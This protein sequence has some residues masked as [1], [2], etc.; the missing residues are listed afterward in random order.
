[1]KRAIIFSMMGLALAASAV[2][3]RWSGAGFGHTRSAKYVAL[4]SEVDQR[5]LRPASFRVLLGVTDANPTRWDGSI[6]AREAGA[7]TSE[8]WRFE[9]V[10]NIKG[11]IF[12]LSTHPARGFNAAGGTGVVASGFIL[13]ADNVTEPS[14]ESR[15]HKATSHSVRPI[16]RMGTASTSWADVS[17]LTG[18]LPQQ[19]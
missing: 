6:A 8:G 19:G 15:P 11:P 18:F 4:A 10:D 14:S 13:N 16:Y 9:G 1:M 17:T 5:G 12:H 2:V 3:W 7:I